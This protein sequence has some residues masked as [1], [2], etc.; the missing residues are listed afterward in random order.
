MTCTIIIGLFVGGHL[1]KR[2]IH[3]PSTMLIATSSRLKQPT[4]VVVGTLM[5][6]LVALW[7]MFHLSGIEEVV[8]HSQA[9]KVLVIMMSK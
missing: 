6:V 4:V 8:H 2:H 3:I 7:I 5:L 9:F 1:N